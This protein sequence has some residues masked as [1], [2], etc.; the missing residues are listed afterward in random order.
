MSN[1]LVLLTALVA[2]NGQGQVHVNAFQNAGGYARTRSFIL[3]QHAKEQCSSRLDNFRLRSG[4][5]DSERSE[6]MVSDDSNVN[7]N[8]NSDVVKEID[9]AS[10]FNWMKQW[11]PVFPVGFLNELD[12]DKDPFGSRFAGKILSF[13]KPHLANFRLARYV[14]SST[15][16]AFDG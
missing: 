8:V 6:A 2:G 11:Y 16:A 14:P 1:I 13:G 4:V 10:K 15:G 12:V 3:S 5:H 7:V 9:A